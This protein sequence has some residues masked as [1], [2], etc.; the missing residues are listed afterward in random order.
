[1]KRIIIIAMIAG[2]MFS[3]GCASTKQ[4]IHTATAPSA[5]SV[6]SRKL[7]SDGTP[8][9]RKVVFDPIS[10]DSEAAIAKF[11]SDFRL[12]CAS[13]VNML[14][15]TMS[16]STLYSV[17]VNLSISESAQIVRE[18]MRGMSEF[19]RTENQIQMAQFHMGAI[20]AC[21]AQPNAYAAKMNAQDGKTER[22]VARTG[23]MSNVF[24]SIA[25]MATKIGLGGLAFGALTIATGGSISYGPTAAEVDVP[26]GAE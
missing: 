3:T 26:V 4:K 13:N 17:P 14:V 22:S 21:N 9:G 6:F 1:M 2:A 12:A 15:K 7:E 11:D 16:V 25:D 20:A 5:D 23:M 8:F 24:T 18:T 19:K 10:L